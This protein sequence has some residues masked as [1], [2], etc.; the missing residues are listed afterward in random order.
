[1]IDRDVNRNVWEQKLADFEGCPNITITTEG[2]K[3]TTIKHRHKST[4]LST[5][6]WLDQ[7]RSHN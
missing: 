2:I 7:E 1:M 3:V 5:L 4:L 6:L